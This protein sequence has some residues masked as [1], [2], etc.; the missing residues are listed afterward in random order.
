MALALFDL[1]ETLIS[2]DSDFVW[3]EYAVENNLV[4]ATTHQRQNKRFYEDYKRGQL[5]IDAY[6]R[7]SCGILARHDSDTLLRHRQR[8]IE[9]RIQPLL[10]PRA[11]EL[12]EQH[13]QR[14]DVLVVIT[15]TIEFITQPIAELLGIENLIAPVPERK[16]GRY[17]GELS[18]IPSFGAGKVKRLEAWLASK[19][20]SMRDS[21]FY[22]DSINDVALLAIVDHPVAVDPDPKLAAIAETNQWQ[23]ISLRS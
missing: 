14:G 20:L 22:S 18:G 2:A 23:I 5:D 19:D 13:K 11:F 21:H 1:D 12:I 4:D 17:T 15:A 10:L 16:N 9:Q 7:F 3:G 6:M 8:F